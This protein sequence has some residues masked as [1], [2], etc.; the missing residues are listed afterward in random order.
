MLVYRKSYVLSNKGV[1]QVSEVIVYITLYDSEG[2]RIS[3]KIHSS[4]NM[5]ILPP[6]YNYPKEKSIYNLHIIGCSYNSCDIKPEDIATYTIEIVALE[7]SENMIEKISMGG[8]IVRT[9]GDLLS[10]DGSI[11]NVG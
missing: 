2:Y 7:S 11:K 9:S 3:D 1:Q 10:W 6:G 8:W 5:V 4:H